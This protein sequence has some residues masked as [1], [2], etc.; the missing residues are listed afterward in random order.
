MKALATRV[1]EI[2]IA[3]AQETHIEASNAENDSE[4]GKRGEDWGGD[5]GNMWNCWRHNFQ[6]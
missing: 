5:K 1:P 3:P 4:E 2:K 6:E